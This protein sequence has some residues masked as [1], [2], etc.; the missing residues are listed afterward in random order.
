MCATPTNSNSN[1]NSEREREEEQQREAKRSS[2]S[3]RSCSNINFPFANLIK[4]SCRQ[5]VRQ[6]DVRRAGG[7]EGGAGQTSRTGASEQTKAETALRSAKLE[8]RMRAI[9]S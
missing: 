4:I 2:I 5:T 1:N 9:S 6:T 3:R 8:R 7:M